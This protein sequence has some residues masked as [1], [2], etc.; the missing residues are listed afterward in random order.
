MR[1]LFI[2]LSGIAG[3]LLMSAVM[4][5]IHRS[6]WANADM[7]RALG[8]Y[9]TRRYEN[10]LA[11]GLVIHLASGILF[12]FPYTVALGL[13]NATSSAGLILG[14]GLLGLVH[15]FAMSFILLAA[16]SEKHP[17][18]QFRGAG[19]EVGVAHIVGHV[20]YGLGVGVVYAQLLA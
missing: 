7:I 12:A 8:S 10:A 18:E 6:N 11:P 13:I 14:G 9:V 2:A 4:T 17:V 19:L 3:T 15:G 16:V 5:L 20:F 1:F